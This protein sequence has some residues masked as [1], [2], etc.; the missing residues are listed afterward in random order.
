MSVCIKTGVWKNNYSNIIG[1]ISNLN[2]GPDLKQTHGKP[3]QPDI[4]C[5]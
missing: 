3:I 2:F 5:A 1:K 4:I